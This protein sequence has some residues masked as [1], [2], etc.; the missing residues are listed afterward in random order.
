MPSHYLLRGLMFVMVCSV[1]SHYF[2]CRTFRPRTIR[3]TRVCRCY[4]TCVR[5]GLFGPCF[6]LVT[7]HSCRQLHLPPR[8]YS[9]CQTIPLTNPPAS[10]T[11]AASRL[12]FVMD[13]LAL[14]SDSSLLTA[15]A[16]YADDEPACFA[17]G[18]RFA[19]F[20]HHGLLAPSIPGH[21][22]ERGLRILQAAP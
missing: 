8:H 20:V 7:A 3:D 22:I 13:C 1:P 14:A 6:R 18:R 16:N 9:M 15:A 10:Q 11:V 21:K 5:G 2:K 19:A 4:A 12:L 17:V